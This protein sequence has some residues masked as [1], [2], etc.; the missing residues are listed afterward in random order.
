MYEPLLAV[1]T[2]LHPNHRS[3]DLSVT[4]QL[5]CHYDLSVIDLSLCNMLLLIYSY[6]ADMK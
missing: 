2:C 1:F 5:T 3:V 6:W 4:D